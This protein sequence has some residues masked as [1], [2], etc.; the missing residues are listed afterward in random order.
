LFILQRSLLFTWFFVDWELASLWFLDCSRISAIKFPGVRH[1]GVVYDERE[2]AFE[3]A[4][5]LLIWKGRVVMYSII[6]ELYCLREND[7]TTILT[8]SVVAIQRGR[9]GEIA[10]CATSAYERLC[11][12]FSTSTNVFRAWDSGR[13]GLIFCLV[14][15]THKLSFQWFGKLKHRVISEWYLV[16]PCRC[17]H[18]AVV[19]GWGMRAVPWTLLTWHTCWCSKETTNMKIIKK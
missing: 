1:A 9:V 10:S 18:W 2:R 11:P 5:F 8:W 3:T 14:L 19:V 13:T 15:S 16:C 6:A 12:T 7:Y 4:V 17:R